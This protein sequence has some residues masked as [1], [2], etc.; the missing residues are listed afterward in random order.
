[1]EVRKIKVDGEKKLVHLFRM[2]INSEKYVVIV[3]YQPKSKGISFENE[4]Y[5]EMQFERTKDIPEIQEVLFNR[6]NGDNID[7]KIEEL[8]W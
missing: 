3:G 7:N 4:L 6:V 8:T 1:M 2:D 5:K